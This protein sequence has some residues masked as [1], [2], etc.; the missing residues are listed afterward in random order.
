MPFMDGFE[1]CKRLKLREETRGIPVIFLS[2]LND[3]KDKVEG[4]R[5][6]AVDYVNKPVQP[7]ELLVRVKTH[8]EIRRINKE[9]VQK[10]IALEHSRNLLAETERI[11]KVGGWEF[12][13]ATGK[14]T[15]TEGV[16]DIH[17]VEL[18]FEPTVKKG[19]Y[20]YTPDSRF[21]VKRAVKRAIKYGEPFDLELEIITAKG[22]LRAVNAIG[23][24]DL[25][26]SRIY[27]FFQ[28][29]TGRKKAENSLR[30]VNELLTQYVRHSPIYAFIKEVDANESRVL[31]AS[32][33]FERMIGIPGVDM[34]GKTMSD[35]FAPDFAA[36]ITADDL[37]VVSNGVLINH[38]EVLEGHIYTTFKFPLFQGDKRIVAGYTIDITESKKAEAE[39][40]KSQSLLIQTGKIAQIGGWELDA[41]TLDLEWTEELYRIHEVDVSFQPTVSAAIDFYTLASRPVIEQAVQA[42]IDHGVPFDLELEIVT[43]KG[44]HLWVHATGQAEQENDKIK[45]VF[46]V[47]QDITERRLTEEA[48][49]KSEERYRLVADFTY[50]WEYWVGPDQRLIYCSPACER[51]TGYR[52][53]EFEQDPE[54]LIAITHPEDREWLRHHMSEMPFPDTDR[55]ECEFRIFTRTGE[56]R[57]IAHACRNVFG[58]NGEYLGRR[59]SN[60]DFTEYKQMEDVR[61][62][63]AQTNI[64]SENNSFFQELAL[65]LANSLDMVFVCIDRLEENGLNATTLAVWHDGKFED[66]VSY[67][68]KDTP[69]GDVV[70]NTVCCFPEKV[71]E[72][73]PHDEMLKDLKAD[74]YIGVTLWSHSGQPIGLIAVIGITPLKNRSQAE[75]LLKMVS[76]RAAGELERMDAETALRS[77]EERYR[78]LAESV[79]DVIWVMDIDSEAFRYV[80]PSVYLLRGYAVEEVLQQGLAKSLTPASLEY[81]RS[82][83]PNRIE[84]FHKGMIETFTDEIEQIHKDGHAIWTEVKSRIIVNR[85]T[86]CIESTGVT[87][88]ITDRKQAELRLAQSEAGFRRLSMEFHGL[89]DAIPDNLM[90][91]D[92]NLKVLWANK[93]AVESIGQTSETISDKFCYSMW[94]C[95][96]YPCNYCPTLKSFSTGKAW[97]DTVTRPDGR[98]WDVRSVPLTDEN[99]NLENVIEVN[100]DITEHRKLESQL[101]QSQKME[102]IGTLAGGIAH[103]F[104]N[105]L[106]VIC[107]YGQ[108]TLMNMH[109]TDPLRHNIECMLQGSDRAARLTQELL[110]F[111]RKKESDKKTVNLN[112]IVARMEKFLKKVI[113]EDIAFRTV[114]HEAGIT[115][116]ADDHQIEQVLMNL[117]TNARDSMPQG[118][119]LTVSTELF[120]LNGDFMSVHGYGKPGLYAL[121]SVSDN[122]TGM[123]ESTRQRIFEPFF[124]TKEVGKG[125]GLGLAVV[126]GIVKQHDGYIN[127]YSEQGIGT[128][129]RIYLPVSSAEK[130]AENLAEEAESLVGGTEMILLA[131]DDEMVRTMTSS[132][133]TEQGYKVIEAVDGADAVS[134]FRENKDNIDLLLIDLIMPKMN[135]KEAFDEIRKIRSEIKVIFSSGYTP[136]TISEKLSP[137]D[138]IQ[139]I[140]KPVSPHDLL[141][142]VRRSLDGKS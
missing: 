41:E 93:A 86:G 140:S 58:R 67:A 14:Q 85:S 59:A 83:T 56:E 39:L 72:Y 17:E 7:E 89:L 114:I 77:S 110:L 76:V 121:L 135:G 61:T 115:V 125:T 37:H 130:K 35:L 79:S 29:I 45:K 51:I 73:F 124:T 57:W 70:G 75:E 126:Y 109:E 12:D 65:Y 100:R 40:R 8:L 113:G 134:R 3:V 127:V 129:F 96:K 133:L 2:G 105:I 108:I 131:E 9:L 1:V 80:S 52:A 111:S 63:L 87:R 120:K 142:K 60:R 90:L 118:G 11:G 49:L 123:D 28:D 112:E 88:D 106:T 36:I 95:G 18:S 68:L 132:I 10:T 32:D 136:D 30:E 13:I 38:E 15:W 22:N 91:L 81:L 27:G 92:R 62:F 4:F 107:G 71:C 139:L 46:G 102:S 104:N 44:K 94:Q 69:C 26:H 42:A 6:G 34:T 43:A 99:G 122:G 98:I 50:D 103:D 66:N 137:A 117:A 101:R 54:L 21:K 84:R 74:S 64:C 119:E 19:I 25:E 141:R 97:N 33:N 78:L 31:L 47:F 16:Y 128:T 23:K 138:G 82:V 116:L 20:F 55:K 5:L 24:A 53:E 48:L